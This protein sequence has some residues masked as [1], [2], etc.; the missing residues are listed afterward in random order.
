MNWIECRGYRFFYI[1]GNRNGFIIV[2]GIVV[3][4]LIGCYF[5]YCCCKW[6]VVGYE[7][8]CFVVDCIYV[9]IVE[10]NVYDLFCVNW[11][12]IWNCGN[13]NYGSCRWNIYIE[14]FC[15]IIGIGNG[16]CIVICC[17]FGCCSC[18]LVVILGIS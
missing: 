6:L 5:I 1:N 16:Y 15:I 3:G 17:K 18:C 4:D 7:I 8:V 14:G 2:I 9:G 13:C 10:W 12:D 11:I